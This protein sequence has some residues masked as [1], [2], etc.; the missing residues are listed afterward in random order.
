MRSNDPDRHNQRISAVIAIMTA[1][2]EEGGQS[3]FAWSVLESYIDDN[4]LTDPELVLAFWEVS[5]ILLIKLERSGSNPRAV[6]QDIAQRYT[7]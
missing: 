6:L 1:W 3:D 4:D 7:T 2:Y 5:G